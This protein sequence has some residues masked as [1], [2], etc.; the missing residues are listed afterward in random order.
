MGLR[1]TI[2]RDVPHELPGRQHGDRRRASGQVM[3]LFAVAS[4]VLVGFVALSI[5]TGFLMAERRQV[6]NAADAAALAGAKALLDGKPGQI[7]ASAQAYGIQN[8]DVAAGNVVVSYP[9]ASGPYANNNLYVQVTITKEVDKYFVGALY[10]GSWEV[11]ATAVA[12]VETIPSDYGLIA[13]EEPGI[14]LRGNADITITNGGSAMS[15]GDIDRSGNA[16]IFV[17]AG[18]IDAHG[19]VNEGPG[20]SAPDGIRDQQPIVPD[21]IVA[22]GITPPAKPINPGSTTCTSSGP[23]SD[24][25]I[26]HGHFT[27][28]TITI[29]RTATMSP[30][31][32]Y[33]DDG[34]EIV[35]VGNNARLVGNGVLLYFRDESTI[36]ITPGTVE[37]T[38]LPSKNKIAIWVE[39]DTSLDA[40]G[41]SDLFVEGIIYAPQA[42]VTLRGTGADVVHGQVFVHDLE[43]VGTGDMGIRYVKTVDTSRP[44]VFLVE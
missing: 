8:A 19:T 42:S 21:P 13:L 23:P 3:I 2:S 18:T 16:N 20:W 14:H 15:N 28:Q 22:A 41:N 7:T 43:I 27:N 29:Q 38:G 37:L 30:G 5:D 34:A 40:G 39:D 11:E 6:Q 36:S 4:L 35:L 17:T 9:P 44:K 12:G 24:C 33:F 32:Y 1:K 31:I 10:S 25:L 26:T